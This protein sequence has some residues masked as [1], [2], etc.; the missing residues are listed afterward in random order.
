MIGDC[1]T[2]ALVGDDGSIDWLCLPW[3]DSAACFASLLGNSENGRFRIAP[4]SPEAAVTRSYRGGSLVL[5]TQYETGD[6]ACSVIDFMPFRNGDP[7]VVRIVQ[8]KRGEIA[9]KLELIIRFDYGSIVPWVRKWDGGIQAIAGPDTL[10]LKSSVPLHGENL[11]TISDF[12]IKAG[13]K[14]SFTLLWHPSHLPHPDIPDPD[15]ALRS[16][17]QYWQQWAARTE[18]EGPYRDAVVRS[19]ITLKA[20][21]FAPTGGIVAAPTTSLPEQI[22][23]MRNWDYR[24]CW[25]RDATFTLYSL[26]EAGY[27]A[28]AE[29]FRDWLLRAVAG[30]PTTLQI[31]YSLD[32]A[33][34]LT[35]LELEWLPGYENSRPVRIGNAASQ[36]LQ[37]DVYGEV[38]D[39][40]HVCR[41]KGVP[42]DENA[43]RL[44]VAML[45][46]L[47]EGWKQPD[48]GIW[49]VRGPRRHFV[50]SK[51][52]AW[53][54]F[55]RAVK[56]VEKFGQRGPVD[57]WREIRDAIKQEVCEQGYNSRLG[58]FVQYYG[59]NEPDASLLMLP[60]VGFLD[61]KDPRLAG[62]LEAVRRN[63]M[64]NGFVD[65]YATKK[66]VDGL[67]TGEGSFL[68][69]S[70]WYVDNLALLKRWDEAIEMFEALLAARN[71]L[72]LLAEEFD[73]VHNRLLGNFPQAFS[74]VGLV[75]TA[76]NLSARR[77][78]AEQ[79]AKDS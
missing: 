78:P 38:L 30:D 50:H 32:G 40:L 72:G 8:G 20:L 1:Q 37:H 57:R 27:R 63:L 71:D 67:P 31:M 22:G 2:A 13:E 14:L 9:M 16:T 47:E 53:V 39:M 23:G 52:M 51:V 15:E 49:E 79:R 17:E 35:E 54:A 41:L 29:S 68:P 73:P 34:R 74:H 12:T 43:W 19:L 62:T 70:F 76:I 7:S 77:G 61:E 64:R 46:Y 45:G 25:L 5:E 59:S 69:C 28:E 21:I 26:L 36:Q 55:D 4:A 6:G 10:V 44:E 56:A 60:L 11:R 66:S 48:E 65:R 24:Y 18:Y 58:S 3:F 42:V 75:N 33:R